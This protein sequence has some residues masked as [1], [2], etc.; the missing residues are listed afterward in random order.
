M[1]NDSIINEL[2]ALV[3][4]KTTYYHEVVHQAD[5]A[6]IYSELSLLLDAA[7]NGDREVI[8]GAWEGFEEYDSRVHAWSVWGK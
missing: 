7:I 3:Q 8:M 2:L 1:Y 6:Y 4:A 5:K